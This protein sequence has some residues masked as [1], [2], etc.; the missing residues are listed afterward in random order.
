VAQPPDGLAALNRAHGKSIQRLSA[1]RNVGVAHHQVEIFIFRAGS[2]D[3][4][5]RL[6]TF[7]TCPKGKRECLVPGCGETPL[8]QQHEDFVLWP[9]TFQDDR[10]IRLYERGKGILQQTSDLPPE[11]IASAEIAKRA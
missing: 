9:S 1:G 6:C 7:S 5:G 8:L 11:G 4:L 10:I 3:Y 2:N